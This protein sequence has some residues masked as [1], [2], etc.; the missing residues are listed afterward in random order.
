M[1]MRTQVLPVCPAPD[2]AAWFVESLPLCF[3]FFSLAI[4]RILQLLPIR[5]TWGVDRGLYGSSANRQRKQK[6][7]KM[8]VRGVVRHDEVP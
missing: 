7:R 4:E 3:V 6:L 8:A 2:R 1:K 5:S